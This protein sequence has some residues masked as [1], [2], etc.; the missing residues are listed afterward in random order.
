MRPGISR[1]IA[2]ALL[3]CVTLLAVSACANPP[4]T[5]GDL[6]NQWPAI[7]APAGW[8]PKVGTC[9]T[10]FAATLYRATHKPV[11]C[12]S[13]HR[14]E[15]VHL[16]Q[17]TGDA[18]N[19]GTPPSA[20]SAAMK[21]AWAECDA[22]TTEFLGGD[23]RDGRIW[24]GVS[25]PS[26]GNWAG[27]ARWFR[28][29]VSASEDAWGARPISWSKSLKGEFSGSSDLKFGCFINPPE[30]EKPLE[31]VACTTP[32][33]AEFVGVVAVSDAWETL[34]DN[35]P[36]IHTKCRSAIA[37]YVGVPDDS[38]LKYRT[39]SSYGY[40]SENEWEAGNKTVRCH[41]YL[42]KNVTRSLKGTGTGGLPINYR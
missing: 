2:G 36:S 30:E 27:G 32:H 28:C 34:K 12:A 39:G 21:A 17:F 24:F 20:D 18:L 8:E 4:G 37:K 25:V 31:A 23:W 33:N 13:D 35:L 7:A 5:D 15:T 38:N 26:S 11:D 19:P 9:H 41:I 14:Y 6:T 40:P 22:K 1:G 42:S 10:D 3:A 16:G 29:E